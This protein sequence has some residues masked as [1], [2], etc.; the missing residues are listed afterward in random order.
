M[1]HFKQI[2]EDAI[3]SRAFPGASLVVG[4]KQF[5]M[6][7]EAVG[8][9]DY[10]PQSPAV[11]IDT[12]YDVASL[13]KV[14]VTTTLAMMLFEEG[15]LDLDAPIGRFT[16]RQLLTHSSGLPARPL[17]LGEA[18]AK[19]RVRVAGFDFHLE[20]EPGTKTLYSDTGFIL[21]GQIIEHI[22]GAPL[23]SLARERI[24]QPLGMSDTCFN[25]GPALVSRIP[26]TAPDIRGRVHDPAAAALGGVA[27]HAGLFSTARDLARFC[28]MMLRGGP[29]IELFTHPTESV[30][31][32][33]RALGWDTRSDEGSSSGHYFSMKSFG[34]TGFTGTSMWIDP[35]R[36]LY[37]IFLTNRVYPDPANLQI[38]DIRPKLH[39]A[40][41]LSLIPATCS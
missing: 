13:T 22:G 31:G 24:F 2:L 32:S 39:D 11:E 4:D 38:R 5:N 9:F 34:H 26:P 12:I 20:Y 19:R 28:R 33:S 18:G 8:H 23:D 41:I 17:P 6:I 21:L 7:E 27:G 3:R 14:V 37:V 30:P 25:P 15:K 40:I 16:I 10:D 35:M 36:E 29:S 1:P